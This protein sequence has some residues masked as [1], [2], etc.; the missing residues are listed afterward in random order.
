MVPP[1]PLTDQL[2]H[3][4]QDMSIG[5]LKHRKVLVYRDVWKVA[6]ANERRV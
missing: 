1:V 2:A 3:E 4:N 6:K 5:T